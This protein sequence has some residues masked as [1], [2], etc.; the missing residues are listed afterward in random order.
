[1][2]LHLFD[3][4]FH[5]LLPLVKRP[6]KPNGVLL[7]CSRG[8]A[9]MVFLA[10]VITR[11]M[12]LA[13]AEEKVS[14]L[15]RADAGSM[16]FL[17][18]RSLGILRID[19]GKLAGIAYR[20]QWFRALYQANYRLVVSLDWRRDPDEDE[21]LIAA[22]MAPHMMAMEPAPL[23]A[24]AAALAEAQ[25]KYHK[26]VKTGPARQDKIVRWAK[27]AD[28]IGPVKH[29]QVTA[30][31]PEGR[32]PEAAR[33][34]LPTVVLFPFSGIRQRQLPAALWEGII[35]AMPAIWH[36]RIAGHQADFHRNPQ[37]ERLLDLPRVTVDTSSFDHMASVL[38]GARMV[39]GT[40]TA[41]VHL[42]SLLGVPTLCLASAAYVGAGVPYD[43]SVMPANAHFIYTPLE[44]QGC[45][46][47][48]P[49][50]PVNGMFPCVAGIDEKNVLTFIED[51]IARGGY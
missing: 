50:D 13:E 8:P 34:E 45:M 16:M 37:F 11:F 32:M 44:C 42:S 35:K 33:F 46:G 47:H 23:P 21:A 43:D 4:L 24:K 51:M 49:F 3:R 7:V 2:L 29:G 9:E 22:T 6:G 19:H 5:A 39:I 36:I 25:R 38:R 18:P 27:F 30:L 15:I 41:G 48:C 14:F 12:R 17:M 40:D 10:P 1:M 26:L 31:V 20:W 28:A